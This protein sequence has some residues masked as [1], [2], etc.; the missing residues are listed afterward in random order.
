MSERTHRHEL[1]KNI[2]ADWLADKIEI[3]RPYGTQLAVGGLVAA[4]VLVG[5]IYYFSR[6]DTV[7]PRAWQAYFAAFGEPKVADALKLAY[8]KKEYEG[9]T[10]ELWARLSYADQRF[11][12]ASVQG[13]QDSQEAKTALADAEKALMEIVDKTSDPMLLARIRFTLARVYESQ[14][15]PNKAREFY[16]QIVEAGKETALGKRAAAAITRLDPSGETTAVLAW[17]AEQKPV[18]RP[19]GGS[20]PFL[21]GFGSQFGGGFG[22]QPTLPER[23]NLSLPGTGS[24]FRPSGSGDIDFGRDDPLGTKGTEPEGTAPDLNAPQGGEPATK[25]GEE[26]AS[27]EK[28]AEPAKPADEKPASDKTE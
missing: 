19:P 3:L 18:I 14:H 20:N 17:L 15:K 8:E 28:P 10:A 23:P 22:Q 7:A 11:Q 25:G 9:T 4:A 27:D 24:P 16:Q 6:T 12:F 21:D 26:K 5:A 1:E 13:G 2:L